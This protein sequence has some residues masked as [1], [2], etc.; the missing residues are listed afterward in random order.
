MTTLQMYGGYLGLQHDWTTK[1]SSNIV[2]GHTW[3][4]EPV[5]PHRYRDVFTY[6]NL[7]KSANY[8]AVNLL[9]DFIPFGRVGIEYLF[10]TKTNLA[11]EKGAD[12]RIN[13]S[14]RY[15]F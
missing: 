12:H 8:F 2:Y 1:L 3:M 7:Y 11:R 14:M 6:N 10:G 9:W 15:D 13:L 4:V 5:L